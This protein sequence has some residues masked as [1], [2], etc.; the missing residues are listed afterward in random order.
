M[1][2]DKD[3]VGEFLRYLR[4]VIEKPHPA[5]GGL[6]VCPFARKARL[7]GKIHFVVA[8]LKLDLDDPEMWS[9]IDAL[10]DPESVVTFVHPDK[11]GVTAGAVAAFTEALNGR[12]RV[13]GKTAFGGHPGDTLEVGGFRPHADPYPNVQVIMLGTI[14][15]KSMRLKGTKYYDSWPAS[16]P[17]GFEIS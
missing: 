5:F 4:E 2:D 11:D 15:E 14:R 3:V 1:A 6:P 10:T 16:L 13:Y 7:A 12:L 8:P 17:K 9:E